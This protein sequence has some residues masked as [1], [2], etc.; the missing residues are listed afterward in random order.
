[1][2]L[3]SAP[4]FSYF[5]SLNGYLVFPE[6]DG[7]GDYTDLGTELWRSDGTDAGTIVVA[8]INTT[9]VDWRPVRTL[10]PDQ[11]ERCIVFQ[12]R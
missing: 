11:R 2:G 6:Y 10:L 9:Y 4:D 1:M 3:G 7:G 8:D 5:T 12:R